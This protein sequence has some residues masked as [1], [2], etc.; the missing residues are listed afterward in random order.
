MSGTSITFGVVARRLKSR[1][2]LGEV[3]LRGLGA[4]REGGFCNGCPRIYSLGNADAPM[5]E[6]A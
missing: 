4:T 1:A 3:R 2:T 5:S 6:D